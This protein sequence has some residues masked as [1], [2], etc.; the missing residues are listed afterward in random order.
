MPKKSTVKASTQFIESLNNLMDQQ[1]AGRVN[2]ASTV[3]TQ[4]VQPVQSK[5]KSKVAVSGSKPS[6]YDSNDP[7]VSARRMEKETGTKTKNV[8][9]KVKV[10]RL[11]LSQVPF[12]PRPN[13][14][15]NTPQ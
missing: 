15:N 8:K 1:N 3:K 9:V 4:K 2:R 12:Q 7:K 5:P 11:P 6:K 14:T 13:T 10:P